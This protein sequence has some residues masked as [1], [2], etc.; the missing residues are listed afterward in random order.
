ME[1][2]KFTLS[3]VMP[4]QFATY[5]NSFLKIHLRAVVQELPYY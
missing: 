1:I 2:N 5:V 4:K 3:L